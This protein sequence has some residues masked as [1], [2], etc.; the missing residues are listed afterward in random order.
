MR[1]SS[2]FPPVP[3]A[4]FPPACAPG[5][6]DGPG[7]SLVHPLASARE[8]RARSQVRTRERARDKLRLPRQ[9]DV[10][11][12]TRGS[13][14]SA[15]G[16]ALRIRDLRNTDL[17]GATVSERCARGRANGRAL[18]PRHCAQYSLTT[19][20]SRSNFM[21][22]WR[23]R[24]APAG[25]LAAAE[26]WTTTG[27]DANSGRSRIFWKVSQPFMTGIEQI[28]DHQAEPVDARELSECFLAVARR[29]DRISVELERIAQH[30]AEI[31]L[32]FHDQNDVL[33]WMNLP[34]FSP[35][36]RLRGNVTR[37]VVPSARLERSSMV[38]PW[39]CASSFEM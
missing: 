1:R 21:G 13:A 25:A 20:S 34:Y 3:P 39:A 12:R 23:T 11:L 37:N 15:W 30:V 8:P 36:S 27:T 4:T 5:S 32:V 28:Q 9:S 16:R 10:Y 19:E 33:H 26:E 24:V 22:F 14:I 29:D 18:A 2:R 31:L 7:A 17:H 38:P 35:R 6:F